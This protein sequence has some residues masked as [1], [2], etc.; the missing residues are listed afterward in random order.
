[1]S[2]VIIDTDKC[3]KDKLCVLECPMKIITLNSD[4]GIPETVHNAENM[5]LN[6][7]HCIAVCPYGALSLTSMKVEECHS[8]APNWNPGI[9]TI[10][11][12]F[13]ARRSI[14]R[15][16]NKT[17]EKE[18]LEKLIEI[19]AYAPTGHNS[20]TVEYLIFTDKEI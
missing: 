11:N 17:V 20:R 16:K 13:K 1:M 19:T 5:C 8:V 3:K 10:G 6:C 14:R 7:G 18:I 2:A 12:Y 9:E 15:F 4:T